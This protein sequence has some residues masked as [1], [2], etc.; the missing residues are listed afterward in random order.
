MSLLRILKLA[1]LIYSYKL[2]LSSFLHEICV[3]SSVCDSRELLS[4]FGS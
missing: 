4:M 2:F 1:I 3:V